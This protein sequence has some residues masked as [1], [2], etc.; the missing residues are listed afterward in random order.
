MRVLV[1]AAHPD[2]EVIGLGGTIAKHVSR[3][4]EVYLLV[5][6]EGVS[7]QY[8]N[9]K[10]FLKIRRDACKKSSRFLGIKKIVFRNFPDSKLNLVPVSE[11]SKSISEEI[12]KFKPNRIYTHFF[13]DM[14]QDHRAVS[15]STLIACRRKVDEIYFYEIIGNIKMA[16]RNIF[17]PNT[18]VDVGNFINKKI[19]ALKFYDT[20]IKPF[21]HPLSQEGIISLSKMR[22]VESGLKNAEAFMCALRK[23]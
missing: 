5:I 13:G 10:K 11:V 7:A 12:N 4:D 20:E 21:P 15:E 19:E 1:V 17:S 18:Y 16:S 6:S 14:H 9:K 2:D 22:G 23:E 8:R 3:G